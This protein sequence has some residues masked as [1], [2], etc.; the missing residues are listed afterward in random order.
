MELPTSVDN[1]VENPERGWWGCVNEPPLRQNYIIFTESLKKNQEKITNN[2]VKL[3]NQTP[4]CKCAPLFKKSW[5]SPW[6]S[7]N[8]SKTCLKR[9][10]EKKTNIGF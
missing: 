10:H 8:Y 1:S 7:K 6:T 4:L 5:I 9:S 2:Q 3:T